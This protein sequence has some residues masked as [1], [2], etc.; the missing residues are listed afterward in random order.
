MITYHLTS[1]VLGIAFA[2]AILLLVRRDHLRIR[3]SVWWLLVAGVSLILGLF[4]GVIDTVGALFG[5]AYPP[6]LLLILGIAAL[7]IKILYM[8]IEHSRLERNLRRLT[9]RIAMYEADRK[10]SS[11][12][13]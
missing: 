12:H 10:D 6:T 5:V 2:A 9:Q 11:L 8:D 13:E 3:Y 1:A 4:P 7:L